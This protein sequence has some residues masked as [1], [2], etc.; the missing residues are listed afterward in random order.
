MTSTPCIQKTSDRPPPVWVEVDAAAYRHNLR[1]LDR[2][3]QS[4]TLRM[5][6]IKANAYGH[7]ARLIA[8]LAVAEGVDYLGVHSLEEFAEISDLTGA[9]PVCL[10]G[11]TLP[12]DAPAV[13]ASGAEVTV[14]DLRVAAALADAARAQ[15]RRVALH[16]KAETGTHRQGILPDEIPE[17]GCFFEQHPAMRF[18]GLHTH[19]ANIEDTTD[20]TIARQ[21]LARLRDIQRRFAE[22][23]LEPDLVHSACSAAAI[24]MEQTH[25]N[26]VR[27]GIASYGLWPSRETFL[28]TL[29]S[30]R[31][32]PELVPALSW[33]TRIAQIK[34]VPDGEYVGYGCTFRTTRAMR[35][36]VLPV[37]YYD[38]YDRHLSG[39]G[40][41][42]V[43]GR[44][45]PIVG[46]VCMNMTMVDV[47]DIPEADLGAE[48]ILIG[49][50][51]SES[52][53]A[54]T[55]AALCGTI[56]YE[57]VTRIG[58]HLPRVL[59]GSRS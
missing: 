42:L 17:W 9:T 6:V 19:Y 26:L 23:G 52:V 43:H 58:R 13:V 33:K 18:R 36:A 21:Q 38:G 12:D 32:G 59:R 20:H 14:S 44:R 16:V 29:L 51:G 41:V 24:V 11:P 1:A 49:R 48:V 2:V 54:D 5:A 34:D 25:G 10:L 22:A 7:G 56:N 45:A 53:S 27:L 57:I 30:H 46:R 55:L 28:S 15:D 47:T 8:P 39:R 3:L 50:S 40:H 37:G 35:L 31:M 4:G